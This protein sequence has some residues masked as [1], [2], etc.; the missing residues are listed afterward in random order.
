MNSVERM[1]SSR[2]GDNDCMSDILMDD[3]VSH[4]I[5]AKSGDTY[6]PHEDAVDSLTAGPY[7]VGQ[8]MDGNLYLKSLVGSSDALVRLPGSESDMVIEHVKEFLTSKDKYDALNLVW[9]RGFLL[10]GPPGSGK[11]VTVKFVEDYVVNNCNGIS[12]H[13]EQPF[14]REAFKIIRNM[15]SDRIILAIIE[16]ID[17]M[18][19][20]FSED[21]ILDMLDGHGDVDKIV[22]IA[23]T[24]YPEN[25][26][27][28]IIDRP[29]RFDVVAKIG[30]PNYEARLVYIKS[31]YRGA[32]SDDVCAIAKATDYL[33]I[34]HIKEVVI[35]VAVYGHTVEES[36]KRMKD[37]K[38]P[39]DSTEPSEHGGYV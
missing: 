37:M 27:K 15:E 39:I 6:F 17:S 22:F 16:D 7:T 18:L 11:T 4:N 2:R 26:P 23:T 32:S 28:R 8:T 24:N 30:L 38:K 25:L 5:W 19:E 12:L 10:Y 14:A 36:T 13:V 31:I 29:S 35:G 20:N 34:A 33:S 9:K 3:E 21:S 1:L